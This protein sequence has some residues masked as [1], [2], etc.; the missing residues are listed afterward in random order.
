MRGREVSLG[1]FVQIVPRSRRAGSRSCSRSSGTKVERCR[2]WLK[3]PYCF[4][5]PLRHLCISVSGV[6]SFVRSCPECLG[7]DLNEYE[8]WILSLNSVGSHQFDLHHNGWTA[9]SMN[10]LH[11]QEELTDGD[12]IVG[13][14]C[15]HFDIYWVS[16]IRCPKT[17]QMGYSF[18]IHIKVLPS[19]YFLEESG[20]RD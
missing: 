17:P 10:L 11:N 2:E 3:T 15:W 20:F 6:C 13:K 7:C 8:W 19:W 14:C 4:G 5:W 1:W 16:W 12:W 9:D 18:R